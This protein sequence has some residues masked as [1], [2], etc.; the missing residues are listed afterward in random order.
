MGMRLF[1]LLSLFLMSTPVALCQKAGKK[2]KRPAQISLDSAA[3]RPQLELRSLPP[4]ANFHGED[5]HYSVRYG[6]IEAGK[7]RLHVEA[8]PDYDGRPTWRVVGT[9]RS[10]RAFD[11][12]FKVRDHYET[13]IDQA[14]LFPHHFIRRVREGGYRLE[15]DIAFDAKRRTS[16][17]TQ[18]DRVSHHALP[19]F[20]QD[21]VSAF[22]YARNLPIE[23]MDVGDLI[24]IPT[25][26]DGKIHPLRARLT[27]RGNVKVK[28]GEFDCW[29]F[30]PVVQKGRI[31]KS[32]SDLTVHVSADSRRIPVLVTSDLLIGSIRL[33]L[34]ADESADTQGA[35][36]AGAIGH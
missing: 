15:R 21:L 10:L 12:A 25:L 30:S 13:H 11:W 29:S 28:S 22:Y 32:D 17:T 7:A 6:F 24:E 35:V 14:G 33:E 23:Q 4:V 18:D 19:A 2:S 34:E 1:L 31:W 20:C 36:S 16:T 27:G 3:S 26:I 9:G 5:L 8:G